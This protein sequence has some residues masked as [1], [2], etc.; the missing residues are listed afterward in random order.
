MIYLRKNGIFYE[1]Y[2]RKDS[3]EY[4]L[5]EVESVIPYLDEIIEIDEDVALEDFFLVVER[6]EEL[7]EVIFSSQLG[8]HRL[9]VF[10]EEMKKDCLPE[11][12]EDLDFIECSWVADQFDYKLF[13]DQHK[14][15]NENKDNVISRLGG[16]NLPT[17]EENE[18][19]IYVDVHGWGKYEL[20][21]HEPYVEGQEVLT[22]TSYGIEFTPLYRLKHL[23]IRLNRDFIM[24]DRN[25]VGENDKKIVEGKKDFS[26]FEVFGAILSE[27][28]FAGYPKDRDDQWK[29]VVDSVEKFKNRDEKDEEE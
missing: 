4:V 17:D 11:S 10:L 9:D 21:E 23:P 25:K 19:S 5:K 29:N 26:V 18:I 13:Y 3:K 16:L 7:M 12:K 20:S 28:S 14:K 2:A 8:H 24:R 1:N 27:I 22:H 15:E 6:D